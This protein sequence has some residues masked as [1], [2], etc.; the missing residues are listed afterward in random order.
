MLTFTIALAALV[1]LWKTIDVCA[2]ID[3]HNFDGH[4]VHFI[5]MAIYWALFGA[6][7]VAVAARI[8]IGGEMLLLGLAVFCLVNRRKNHHDHA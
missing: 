5:G 3:I 8:N 1:V 4:P 6:G 2:S 7:A